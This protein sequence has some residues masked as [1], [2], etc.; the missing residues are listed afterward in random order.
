[1]RG[2]HD[3]LGYAP[4]GG[5]SVAALQRRA[6]EFAL[7]AEHSHVAIVTHAGV[8]RT[9]WSLAE[10]ARRRVVETGASNSAH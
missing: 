8:M 1:M 6:V 5:E 7:N 2:A 3:V 10:T 4:P 9:G